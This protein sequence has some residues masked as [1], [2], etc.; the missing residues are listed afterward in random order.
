MKVDLERRPP[1]ADDLGARARSI[2]RAL[3]QEYLDTGGPVASQTLAQ[4]PG[5]GLSPASVRSV[6]ADLEALGYLDKPHVSA[7]RVPTDKAFR[8]YV[9]ALVRVRPVGEKERE[10]ID[11]K[12]DASRAGAT[13]DALE[14]DAPRLLHA[15]THHVGIVWR[16]REDLSFRSID[17]IRL[18]EGRVLA[19]LVTGAGGVRNRL[20]T[21]DFPIAQDELDRFGR[22]LHELL[23][24]ARTLFEAREALARELSG[25]R[26]R[27]DEA[28]GRALS[29]GQR[30][31][32]E[33]EP[34]APALVVE[35]ESSLIDQA[36]AA[37]DVGKLKGFF[38]ALEEKE[39][40][41]KLL[42][43]AVEAGELTLFIGEEAGFAG[44]QGLSVVATPFGRASDPL[45][46]IGVVGPSRMAYARVI[47]IVEYTA[48]VLSRTLDEG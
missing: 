3:I 23:E 31:V 35:G 48:Q 47:P 18:R 46:A 16:P 10:L 39:R 12:L 36:T 30:A 26:A 5:M 17:F 29:L 45:G 6:L 25:E 37:D 38:R 41:A 40:L 7:G 32:A 19:V 15:L 4:K 42:D 22:Y 9:D 8:F 34:E 14:K 44:A 27:L 1:A 33:V 2:L 24:G 28:S 20:L 13:P 43:Q 21:V 11:Q